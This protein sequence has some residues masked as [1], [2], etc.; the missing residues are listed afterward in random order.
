MPIRYPRVLSPSAKAA[1]ALY[2]HRTLIDRFDATDAAA[3]AAR[4]FGITTPYLRFYVLPSPAGRQATTEILRE[5]LA[6]SEKP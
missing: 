3:E 6:A 1:L 5:M 4:T 2:L